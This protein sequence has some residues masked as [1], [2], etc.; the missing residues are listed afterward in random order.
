MRA[1]FLY[2]LTLFFSFNLLYA[3]VPL[4]YY[5]PDSNTYNP[6][7]PT[8]QSV[9]G[10]QVGQWHVSHDQIVMYMRELA[11][12]SDRIKI[13]EIGR[14]YEDRPQLLLTITSPKNHQNIET[15]KADHKK[16]TFADQSA[17]LDTESM[18]AVSLMGYSV[19]G[20]EPS[21]AN[22][23]LLVAYY[24]AAAEE[25]GNML[26]KVV[27]LLDPAFN[28]DGI[29][30]FSTWANMHKSINLNTD[31]NDREFNE[32]WPNGRTNHYWFDL[33]RDWMPVQHPES[34]SR[35]K[36]FH[37]WKPNVLTDHHEMGTNSTYFFQ[38]GIPSRTHPITPQRNQD[39]TELIARH[40][41][42]AL[43]NIGSFYYTQESFDDFYYGKGSTFPDVN[44]G[45]GILFE[46]ASSR[47]HAQESVNGVVAFPFTI[48][49]QFTTSLS[50]FRAVHEMRVD[51]LN[52]QR[53]FFKSAKD[54]AAKDQNKAWIISDK[55]ASKLYHFVDILKMHEI[56]V[57]EAAKDYNKFKKE[58]SIIIPADQQQYRFIKGMLELRTEFTDSL[59]YD[60]SAWSFLLSF[61]FDYEVLNSKNFSGTL[62]GNEITEAKRPVGK[63]EGG[64]SSYAYVFEWT[65]Y[66]APRL[67]N[68][69]AQKGVKT[70]VAT[71]GFVGENG[72][73]FEPGTI[74]IPVSYQE[75]HADEL[76]D[77]IT[78]FVKESGVTVYASNTGYTQ[79]INLGSPS[80]ANLDAPSIAMLVG[81]GVRNADVGEIWH[82]LDQRYA[83]N[84]TKLEADRLGRTYLDKYN[85]IIL[86]D[87]FYSFSDSEKE[88]LRSWLQNGGTLIAYKNGARALANAGITKVKYKNAKGEEK[89]ENKRYA[90]LSNNRG[91]QVIGGA[92]FNTRG[93]LTNPLLYGY[94]KDHLPVFRNSTLF[95]ELSKNPYANPL[96]YTAS[97]LLSGYISKENH[98][99]LEN[100]AAITVS[101]VGRGKVISF[102]DNTNFRAFWFG[103][104]RLLM[105]SIFFGQIISGAAAE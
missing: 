25:I 70:S 94:Q 89:K 90:D 45:V 18:P 62:L 80:M 59:F 55:D 83:I 38:P 100:T 30:R 86:G 68:A 13:Q 73:T 15:I 85:V 31:S 77:M 12:A 71:K 34:R 105:N 44:G 36:V 99:V 61:N 47:G 26:D 8:P 76:Y 16:L 33:N 27:I 51:L 43:D 23:A 78:G 66:Y 92:I 67:L 104:N 49:N 19:H 98:Q 39:L 1:K 84:I 50:T 42:K 48:R 20:N 4:S 74:L 21:G 28:P 102:T 96:Q 29:Q 75:Y 57:Y 82:L 40:H 41:A 97:P 91:A 54:E 101:A 93:D 22:A 3:Q 88:K 65:D 81:S 72:Q 24:F 2:T 60:V 46:Q 17:S 103:T 14:T 79:G 58:H 6:D 52:Y 63:V 9:L 32:V 11:A 37:E 5:L 53:D 87:G 10:F 56:K 64:K 69:L 7:I 95:M 35:I